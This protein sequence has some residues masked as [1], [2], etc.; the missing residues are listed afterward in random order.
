M[1]EPIGLAG[2]RRQRPH[3]IGERLILLDQVEKPPSSDQAHRLGSDVGAPPRT[4]DEA[5]GAA[6]L[7]TA[8]L[9]AELDLDAIEQTGEATV[10]LDLA[11]PGARQGRYAIDG[12]D[13]HPQAALG[14]A[15]SQVQ[16]GDVAAE[17]VLEVDR[18]DQD[19]DAS[20]RDVRDGE[21]ER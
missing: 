16:L 6:D 17:E 21:L 10:R 18:R 15:A 14:E 8:R 2:H 3:G 12:Q 13:P 9:A 20:R 1:G 11:T 4:G 5:I 7:D 19:V